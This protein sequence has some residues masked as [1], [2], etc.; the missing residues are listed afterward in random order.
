M[1]EARTYHYVALGASGRRVRGSVSAGTEAAAFGQLKREGLSPLAIKPAAAKAIGVNSAAPLRE[2]EC[3]DFLADMAALLKAGSDLRTSLTI[4]SARAEGTALGA[5]CRKVSADVSGGGPID[6]AFAKALP[7]RYAFVAALIAAGEATGDLPGGLA[8]ASE[9]LSSRVKLRDQLVAALSYPA[10]VLASTI[11]AFLVILF[12]LVPSLA[13]LAEAA[14]SEPPLTLSILLAT[15]EVLRTNALPILMLLAI[16]AVL[17]AL[18]AATGGLR[19]WTD[20]WL[21]KGPFRRTSGA[22][23]FGSFAIAL[24]DMLAGGTPMTQALR[25]ATRAVRSAEAR[26]Q[27]EALTPAVRDGQ[28]LSTAFG[29]IIG[30]PQSILRLATVGEASGSLGPMIARAGR[31][32]EAAALRRIEAAGRM[33]GPTMII[34]LGGLIGL[35]MA[36]L[37]S[38]I[39]QVGEASLL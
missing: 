12:F 26:K 32:E 33:L 37:L 29:R 21:L 36:G 4:L 1:G 14:G 2:R 31:L 9:M 6:A 15:S 25:L 7:K 38:S 34:A 13:P 20:R 8:R 16:S 18:A 17:L 39:Q 27:L 10:F 3:A 28:P 35:L 19:G 24:G 30:F 22:L 23:V 5:A 11:A